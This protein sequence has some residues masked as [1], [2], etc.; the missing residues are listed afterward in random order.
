MT[1]RLHE[2]DRVVHVCDPTEG[3]VERIDDT[4]PI[5]TAAVRLESGGVVVSAC[6]FW[7]RIPAHGAM[8]RRVG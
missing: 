8:D 6:G 7:E 2:G 1:A 3:V 5:P 4:S